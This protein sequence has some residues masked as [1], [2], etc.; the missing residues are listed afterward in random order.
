MQVTGPSKIHNNE[1]KSYIWRCILLTGYF[2]VNPGDEGAGSSQLQVGL[3]PNWS[4]LLHLLKQ[5]KQIVQ[6]TTEIFNNDQDFDHPRIFHC[7]GD[8]VIRPVY[9]QVGQKINIITRAFVA[10]RKNAF[11][12][13]L[14][15][16]F[17]ALKTNLRMLNFSELWGLLCS[18]FRL[19]ILS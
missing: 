9:F 3:Q 1:K 12:L 19:K 16:G 15:H 14:F 7:H 8:V 10:T 5:Q 4:Q 2:K 6:S 11:V 13:Y 17:Q 18:L